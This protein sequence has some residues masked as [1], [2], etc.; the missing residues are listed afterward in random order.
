MNRRAFVAGI[1]CTAA[2]PVVARAQLPMP[3]VGVLSSGLSDP[4]TP[5]LE[6]FRQGLAEAGYT[7][8]RNIVIKYAWGQEKYEQVPALAADLV[9]NRVAVIVA[10]GHVAARAAKDVATKLPVVFLVG[11]DPVGIGLVKSLNMPGTNMTGVHVLNTD[12]ETKRLELLIEVVPGAD[13]IAFLVNPDSP[14][15]EVKLRDM[16][17]QHRFPDWCR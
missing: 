14:T 12:L 2:W 13:T 3:I 16:R 11:S 15:T 5:Y 8:G 7:D 17:R 9:A 10:L 1:G 6:A 4:A